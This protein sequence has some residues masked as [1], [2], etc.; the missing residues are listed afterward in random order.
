ML[1]ALPSRDDP[2]EPSLIAHEERLG[3]LLRVLEEGLFEHIVLLQRERDGHNAL[4]ESLCTRLPAVTFEVH[5][6]PPAAWHD[7]AVAGDFLSRCCER[8]QERR[9]EAEQYLLLPGVSL[10]M[11]AAAFLVAERAMPELRLLDTAPLEAGG[12]EEHTLREVH[13]VR[14]G[15]RALPAGGAGGLEVEEDEN[16]FAEDVARDLG[17]VYQHPRMRAALDI[18]VTLATH[19]TPILL[20]GET[21]TGKDLL[22]TFVH[23]ISHRRSHRLVAINCAA[24][25]ETLAESIL[26]GHRKGAFTGAH[27]TQKGKF[28]LADGGTLFLDEL[29]ELSLK[30]QAK[31][32]RV[33]EDHLVDPLGADQP[34]Q[35]NVRILAA[36]NRDLEQEVARG[37]FRE[38]L[39]YRLRTGEIWLPPLR[40]RS[41]DVPAIALQLLA[42]VNRS[43]RK[44]K[45]LSREALSYLSRQ[46]WPG[47]VR[48]LQNVIE[49]AA[50][51][52]ANDIL[53][54]E[55][56][57]RFATGRR[58][59]SPFGAGQETPLPPLGDGFS[60]EKHL[61][62]QR[63]L[64][65][66]AALREAGGNQ[67]EAARLLGISPQAVHK[68]VKTHGLTSGRER[69][70]SRS[71]R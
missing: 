27:G 45:S 34:T 20:Q 60:L 47:N 63:R 44:P 55:D 71:R 58:S 40:D 36:T 68:F 69:S 9:P 46:N 18:A 13:I 43:L 42:R 49:R 22:A 5:T 50:M 57:R 8:L 62:E 32:L 17:L 16:P 2:F 10:P 4:A 65:M 14:G 15:A 48:D 23:R 61:S 24:L 54:T 67:S 1:L 59:A 28:E 21:G 31:L 38:D 64:L 41:G 12:W 29:G 30:I 19:D 25:P 39:Y 66:E 56:L 26:F 70:S 33:L 11:R 52:S 6:V 3:P 53:D 51:L 37:T 35:V 7:A